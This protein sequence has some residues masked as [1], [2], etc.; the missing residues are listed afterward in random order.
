MCVHCMFRILLCTFLIDLN[1]A[2][3]VCVF[4]IMTQGSGK[5]NEVYKN[6]YCLYVRNEDKYTAV[7]NRSPSGSAYADTEGKLNRALRC[8]WM[9]R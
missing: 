2:Y 4:C 9:L 3:I 7:R 6:T 5:E 8:Q 1:A